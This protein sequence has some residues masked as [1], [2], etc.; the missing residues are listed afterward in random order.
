[1]YDHEKATKLWG[2]HADRAAQ[3]YAK[4]HGDGTP[5]HK[6]FTPA[7]RKQAARWFANG[8]KEEIHEALDPGAAP[9]NAALN[10][11][12]LTNI[13]RAAQTLRLKGINPTMAAAGHRDFAK[14]AAKNP[15]APGYMLLRKLAPNKAAAVQSLTQAGVPL[16]SSLEAN[17]AEFNQVVQRIKRF[18]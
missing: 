11:N 5:W 9:S 3:K 15:K 12:I 1:V 7:D 14:L 4:E 2:Y 10:R 13:R 8:N 6:M 16:G 18:K 17:P